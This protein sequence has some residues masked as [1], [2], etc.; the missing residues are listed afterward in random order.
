MRKPSSNRHFLGKQIALF[1]ALFIV[2][3]IL[4][5]IL[6]FGIA[7]IES[8]TA[9]SQ[10][11]PKD[12][13]QEVSA[14]LTTQADDSWVLSTEAQ[15][16]L[17]E[18][19]SWAALLNDDGSVVWTYKTPD[20]FP[21]AFT[22]NELAL[23]AHYRNWS[24]Y[25]VY[26]WVHENNLLVVG[27]PIASN[28]TISLSFEPDALM[29][30]P[31]YV[32]V[33]LL[34]DLAIFFLLYFISQRRVVRY[35]D[36]ALEA[37]NDLAQGRAT[38]THFEGPLRTIGN[39]I[40]RVSDTLIRKEHARKS[41]VAGVSHDVRTPLAVIMGRAEQIEHDS[42][43]PLDVRES[44]HIIT[45]QGERIRDL[46]E[47]LNI[48]TQLEYDMQPVRDDEIIIP[49]M[50]R[51][52]VVDYVNQD[53][54][55][56]HPIEVAIADSA[57]A[58]TFQGDEKLLRR[59][60]QNA[61]N[62]AIKHNPDGCHI[63]IRLEGI[64]SDWSLTIADD[65]CGMDDQRLAQLIARLRQDESDY[66]ALTASFGRAT[67]TNISEAFATPDPAERIDLPTQQPEPSAQ[68]S[69]SPFAHEDTPLSP[70][71]GTRPAT[72]CAISASAPEGAPTPPVD[73]MD[74]Y[75]AQKKRKRKQTLDAQEWWGSSNPHLFT[76]Q[77][78]IMYADGNEA[79]PAA[80]YS[81]EEPAH[82]EKHARIGEPT[83][84]KEHARIKT[85]FSVEEP[86]ETIQ[87]HGLG[88]PL[89]ARIVLT[90]GGSIAI[91]SKKNEGFWITMRFTS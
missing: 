35:V 69:D 72:P 5:G 56:K 12:V 39:R 18:H 45:R 36:P 74:Y 70:S 25:P 60:V 13:I 32:L 54:D 83:N 43:A 33:I 14:G 57:H 9:Y 53:S 90:H 44:A 51:D 89:I 63:T 16:I 1:V 88:I 11:T 79:A 17:D 46:V 68:G 87:Q 62:N 64:M 19:D 7:V 86:G 61:I 49:R 26:I 82:T 81:G 77:N 52:V 15:T 20:S 31:L 48:A 37:L 4:D 75:H 27:Y 91:G 67:E 73:D 76:V 41:W 59:A 24:D 10:D 85:D 8:G 80:P 3:I 84:T 2:V 22:A 66:A 21:A 6:L 55:N 40:N 78:R 34:I 28:N 42:S 23:M 29:R 38:Q 30:I 71:K 58:I 47:D 65:G 50:L